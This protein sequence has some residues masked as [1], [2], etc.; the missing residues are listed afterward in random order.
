LRGQSSKAIM[1]FALELKDEERS[2][3]VKN[4]SQLLENHGMTVRVIN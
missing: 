4:I 2:T 1:E 3:Y